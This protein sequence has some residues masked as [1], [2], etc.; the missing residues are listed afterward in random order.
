MPDKNEPTRNRPPEPN[1]PAI[2]HAFEQWAAI[3]RDF[4]ATVGA[5]F[6]SLMTHGFNRDEALQL[7]L[8]WQAIILRRFMSPKE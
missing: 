3:N 7:T 4:A 2:V 5:Y 8:E 1:S 6:A